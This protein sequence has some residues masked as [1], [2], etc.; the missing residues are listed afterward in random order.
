MNAL[1][2]EM[3]NIGKNINFSLARGIGSIGYAIM[4]L[5]VGKL[6]AAYGAGILPCVVIGSTLLLI[7]ALVYVAFARRPERGKSVCRRTCG[8]IDKS[9]LPGSRADSLI[10]CLSM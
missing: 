10:C 4:S 6:T 1:A 2:T 5:S 7:V 9:A 3:L 8:D